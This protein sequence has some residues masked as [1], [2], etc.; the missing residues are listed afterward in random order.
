MLPPVEW[1]LTDVSVGEDSA[2]PA[3]DLGAYLA[4][5]WGLTSNELAV[6]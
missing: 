3:Y 5:L 1:G 4:T 2:P 6:S